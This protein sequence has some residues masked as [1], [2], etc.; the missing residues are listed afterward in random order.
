MTSTT[1]RG[2][3]DVVSSQGRGASVVAARAQREIGIDI[4]PQEKLSQSASRRDAKVFQNLVTTRSIWPREEHS[5]NFERR[6]GKPARG[7]A[8]FVAIE[9]K[10][11]FSG[12]AIPSLTER[13]YRVASN[14]ASSASVQT[15]SCHRQANPKRI[16][17]VAIESTLDRSTLPVCLLRRHHFGVS[18][19]TVNKLLITVKDR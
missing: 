12:E 7:R 4:A 1:R 16:R 17:P 9:M 5:E 10:E 3:V 11:G 6:V 19:R 2:V 15:R 8:D 13:F 18:A 14:A